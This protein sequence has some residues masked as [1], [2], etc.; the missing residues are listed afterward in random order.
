MSPSQDRQVF[1]LATASVAIALLLPCSVGVRAQEHKPA[2]EFQSLMNLRFYEQ[3]GG[4][5]VD[6][7]EMVF[8]PKDAADVRFEI[9]GEGGEV[10]AS[11]P[12]R[13]E[14]MHPFPAFGRLMPDG[15]SG[16]VSVGKAGKFTAGVYVGAEAATSFPFSITAEVSKDPFNPKTDYAREGPWKSLAFFSALSESPEAHVNFHWWMNTRD[17]P[18]G[19]KRQETTVH[20]LKGGQEIAQGNV[21]VICTETDW[22][23]YRMEFVTTG[24][25]RKEY[26]PLPALTSRDGE[27][28]VVLKSAGKQFRSHAFRVKG[29]ALQGLERSRLEHQPHSDWIS[30][31]MIDI[32]SG[33]SSKYQIT[34]LY[35]MTRE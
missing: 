10:V 9:R 32:G 20:I 18:S 26:L 31:R 7:L 19:A 11:L 34:E 30:P 12:L 28:R 27:Y 35:W 33:S 24:A 1:L 21:A 2:V 15:N 13:I 16:M 6:G 4:F 5:F 23:H 29:G 8:P 3:S 17:Q 25:A 22:Q 14:S